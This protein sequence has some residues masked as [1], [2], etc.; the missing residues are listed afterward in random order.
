[1]G[2]A[3][4]LKTL[5]F[6]Q[7]CCLFTAKL[8]MSHISPLLLGFPQRSAAIKTPTS[9]CVQLLLKGCDEKAGFMMTS[10]P[11]GVILGGTGAEGQGCRRA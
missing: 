1:M 7:P 11:S 3:G 4:T 5:G 9:L 6:S 8:G 10:I 2:R